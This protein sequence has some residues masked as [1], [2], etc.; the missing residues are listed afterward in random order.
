MTG[1]LCPDRVVGGR[2]LTGSGLQGALVVYSLPLHFLMGLQR[3][4]SDTREQHPVEWRG[5]SS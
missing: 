3:L 1:T 5:D 4:P 2:G